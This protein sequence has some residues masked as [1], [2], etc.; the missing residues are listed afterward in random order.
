MILNASDTEEEIKTMHHLFIEVKDDDKDYLESLEEKRKMVNDHDDMIL[1]L[2]IKIW[3]STPKG[4]LKQWN[5]C[6]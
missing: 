2:T 4:L 1:V 3:S 5:S 6:L